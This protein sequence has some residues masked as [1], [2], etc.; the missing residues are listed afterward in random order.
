MVTAQTALLDIPLMVLTDI[1]GGQ[2]KV[3]GSR[4]A[5]LNVVVGP[6]PFVENHQF[7]RF[8]EM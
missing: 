4:I 6:V 2:R 8:Y 1:T 7:M 3:S 5:C